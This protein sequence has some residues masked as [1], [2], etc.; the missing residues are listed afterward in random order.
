MGLGLVAA[1][2]ACG[3]TTPPPHAAPAVVGP[4]YEVA[5]GYIGGKDSVLVDGS[6]WTL[7]LY[8]PDHGRSRS[9]CY[10]VCDV[11]WPPL[12]LPSRLSTPLAGP[13]VRK[14]LLG[15]TTRLDG[16]RQVTYRGWPLY[17]FANDTRRG[18][19]AGQDDD[20]GLWF[21]IDAHGNAIRSKIT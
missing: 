19:A 8:V 7:Y 6:G 10:A 11:L 17:L 3:T 15:T 14:S 5:V 9:T 21:V 13:G 1:T 16:T 2:A 20:M 12:L 4:P 18:Q